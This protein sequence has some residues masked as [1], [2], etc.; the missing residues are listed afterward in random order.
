MVNRYPRLDR[1]ILH[2]TGPVAKLRVMREASNKDTG[3]SWP[4][5]AIF[6]LLGILA[7]LVIIPV[8]VHREQGD[9]GVRASA[10]ND[11]R[12][13][14]IAIQ[15]YYSEYY[16][17]PIPAGAEGPHVAG[18]FLMEVLMDQDVPQAKERNP[19]GVAFF[20]SS[21][22][23]DEE[24]RPGFHKPTGTFRDPWGTPYEL[25]MDL[26]GDGEIVLPD[27]YSNRFGRARPTKKTIFVHSA[28]PDRKFEQVDDN[29]TSWE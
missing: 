23:T 14:E 5:T 18:G 7:I 24:H 4:A 8:P 6:I 22:V 1:R 10:M 21:R 17:Y 16:Q 2:V 29:A 26:D 27:Y 28:G 9:G 13:L 25:F 12:Q 3:W 19:R 15:A 11:A 20:E